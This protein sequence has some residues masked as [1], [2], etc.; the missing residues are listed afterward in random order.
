M[1]HTLNYVRI[2]WGAIAP[3]DCTKAIAQSTTCVSNAASYTRFDYRW[4][5]VAR[6]RLE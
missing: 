1:V 6:R 2:F 4:A 5:I 3:R